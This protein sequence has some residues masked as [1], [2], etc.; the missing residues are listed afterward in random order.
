MGIMARLDHLA[1]GM[2]AGF[3][4]AVPQGYQ[5]GLRRQDDQRQEE[6]FKYQQDQQDKEDIRKQAQRG[7]QQARERARTYGDE[8]VGE[9]EAL[10]GGSIS[11]QIAPMQQVIG[12]ATA[13]MDTMNVETPEA[14]QGMRQDLVAAQPALGAAIPRLQQMADQQARYGPASGPIGMTDS[15][16][17]IALGQAQ[18][19]QAMGQKLPGHVDRLDTLD[20]QIVSS[21][22]P[23]RESLFQQRRSALA[24][25]G[26]DEQQAQ[27]QEAVL[28]KT[29]RKADEAR[30]LSLL[31]V[32]KTPEDVIQIGMMLP[33][34]GPVAALA[35]RAASQQIAL[36]QEQLQMQ[37]TQFGWAAADQERQLR[38][39][40]RANAFKQFESGLAVAQMAWS[41]KDREKAYSAY[42]Q[43]VSA[44]QGVFPDLADSYRQS[45]DLVL[46]SDEIKDYQD[47][48]KKI[49]SISADPENLVAVG[50][51][52]G[53]PEPPTT[54]PG[55]IPRP[56]LEYRKQVMDAAK[57]YFNVPGAQDPATQQ[58][59][60]QTRKVEEI[61]RETVSSV[62]A[63]G[64]NQARLEEMARRFNTNLL[65]AAGDT[66]VAQRVSQVLVE[67][68]GWTVV[69]G[70]LVPPGYQQEG[71]SPRLPWEPDAT[72]R[73]ARPVASSSGLGR[74][75]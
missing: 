10:L 68:H 74:A 65:S 33:D 16:T 13:P 70:M 44:L 4:S 72:T 27:A 59:A 6:R 17:Q 66:A 56:S 46:A 58:S 22:G 43:G 40:A 48:V 12:Q 63:A 28:K 8:F 49:I 52:L 32:A 75:W 47:F 69:D 31:Q 23:D 61:V 53:I 50:T 38:N 51:F 57:S 62:T 7:D 20:K 45:R 54:K 39:D 42:D 2:A 18:Y 14:R 21:D 55:E 15:P 1:N 3:A 64:S 67:S 26:F 19:A 30:V 29:L 25:I 36:E 60:E 41:A 9:I 71:S 73:A 5:M 35:M 34:S 37:R 24:E 11:E